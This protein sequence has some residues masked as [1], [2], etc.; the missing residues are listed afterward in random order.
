MF[1]FSATDGAGT[2]LR[3]KRVGVDG[4]SVRLRKTTNSVHINYTLLAKE[5]SVR[6]N[7]LDTTHLHLMPP[8]TW[9]GPNG[10]L[11]WSD[12]S[13]NHR[14]ELTAPSSWTP[15]T[16]LQLDASE[17]VDA[18]SKRVVLLNRRQGHGP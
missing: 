18:G 5:L 10:A 9:F 12:W 11:T 7:H 3:W 16:Q 13:W 8:F 15:A 2:S 4:M 17:T 1:D 6:S 14:V